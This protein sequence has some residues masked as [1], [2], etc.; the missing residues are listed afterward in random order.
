MAAHKNNYEILRLLL[1][2]GAAIPLPHDPRCGCQ[3]CR[4][5]GEEDSVRHSRSRMNA[6]R[7]LCSPSLIALSSRD[8]I[9]TAFQLSWE[10]RRLAI[11]EKEYALEYRQFKE[12]VQTFAVSLLDYIRTNQELKIIANYDHLLLTSRSIDEEDDECFGKNCKETVS[13]MHLHR[14]KLAVKLKQ[15]KFISHPLIQQMLAGLWFSRVSEFQR[16]GLVQQVFFVILIGLMFP[17]LSLASLYFPRT[18]FGCF[19]RTP[20]VRFVTHSASYV[21][22]LCLLTLESQRLESFLIE[23]LGPAQT[24]SWIWNIHSRGRGRLPTV[25]E[26]LIIVYVIGFLF[27]DLNQMFSSGCKAYVSDLWNIVDS[28]SNILYLNWI[29]LR[30]TSI[31]Q[32]YVEGN[33]QDDYEDLREDW[34]P[35]DPMFVSEAFFSAGNILSFLKVVHMV[36]IHPH[37]GPLQISLQRMVFDI[38]KFFFLYTWILFAFSCGLNHLLSYYSWK[39]HAKCY[40]P[41]SSEKDEHSC[42]VWRR[43]SNLFETSQTLFWASF[44]LIDLLNFELSGIKEFTRFWALLMFGLYSIIN[45]VVL[46]NLLI[47]MMSDSYQVI[48]SSRDTEWKFARSKLWLTYFDDGICRPPS[49]FNLLPSFSCFRTVLLY[50]LGRKSC[51]CIKRCWKK[52]RETDSIADHPSLEQ[53]IH[54]QVMKS[55]VRRFITREQRMAEET[56]PVTEDD[57]KE[58]K[59]DIASFRFELL[60]LLKS[61]GFQSSSSQQRN[62]PSLGSRDSNGIIRTAELLT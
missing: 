14:I 5:E 58:I 24:P 50:S 18:K 54:E 56:G 43:F 33:K 22:F 53:V 4:R 10:L 42:S 2:R 51:K 48:S 19:S 15:K 9:L 36:S 59:Q 35:Y 60:D 1:D 44:G 31:L 11:I 41:T 21:F 27:Q 49:P 8:P 40:S 17:I 13:K 39:D 7:A 47:A 20:F 34:H 26:S 23:Y 28:L 3:D 52:S 62:D 45:V 16:K 46:L 6:Y 32:V 38:L 37:L 25:T 61:N 55:L 29:L 57:V 30:V 12:Q